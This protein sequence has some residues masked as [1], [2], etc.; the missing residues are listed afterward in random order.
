[1]AFLGHEISKRWHLSESKEDRSHI[2][3]A[4]VNNS[5]G[6]EIFSEFS[7]LL[8]VIYEGIFQNSSTF[9]KT[10]SEKGQ[11]FFFGLID[12]RAFPVT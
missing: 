6:S 7:R 11:V 4:R 8:Q 10:N 5:H 9:D 3:V 1:M 12:V 2:R